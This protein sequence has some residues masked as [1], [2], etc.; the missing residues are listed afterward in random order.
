[1]RRFSIY[2]TYLPREIVLKADTNVGQRLER[3]SRFKRPQT[4]VLKRCLT[5]YCEPE[6]DYSYLLNSS[7]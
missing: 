7:K 1:M 2:S 3:C 6:L 4:V 5:V